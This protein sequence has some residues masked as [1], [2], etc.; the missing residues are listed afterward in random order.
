MKVDIDKIIS[1]AEEAGSA[2]MRV[3]KKKFSIDLK[4]DNSPIT[5]A[6]RVS[7]DIIVKQLKEFFPTIPILS[8]ESEKIS[9]EER[10]KWEIYWLIDPL[11]GT[12]EFI[13]K[14]GEFTVN[15][16][17]IENGQPILG[18]VHQPTEQKTYF[19][20]K[21]FPA[22]KRTGSTTKLIHAC[23]VCKEKVRIVASRS[24]KNPYLEKFIKKITRYTLSNIGSSLK[25]CVIAEGD[26]DIY[27]RFGPTSEWDTAAAHAIA[28]AAG[29]KITDL[30][31]NDLNYNTK[32]SLLNPP[33]IVFADMEKDWLKL[34]Q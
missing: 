3:Y 31:L 10:R 24:H 9:F 1:I 4:N 17:L 25:I 15:I 34:L 18:V 14:N 22:K 28:K 19:G 32:S 2:I 26:A 8:E 13:K 6:D 21:N 16:A 27:P 11:D 33:F 5:D 7:H 12:K 20:G 23:S 30:K 29:A